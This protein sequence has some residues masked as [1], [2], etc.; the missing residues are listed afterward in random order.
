MK[1][2]LNL[3]FIVLLTWCFSLIGCDGIDDKTT[4]FEGTW[5][6]LFNGIY[7]QHVFNANNYLY[8]YSGQNRRK[9]TF[10]YSEFE[11]EIIFS[12][13]YQFDQWSQ[14]SEPF[15][16][17]CKYKFIDSNTLKVEIIGMDRG[18]ETWLRITK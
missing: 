14:L 1:N 5:E 4:I 12:H 9:G 10:I 8:K 6:T 3:C 2:K 18:E 7:V 15:I 17:T 13:I 16:E 11:I